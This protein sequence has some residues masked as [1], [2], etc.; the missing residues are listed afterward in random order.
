VNTDSLKADDILVAPLKNFESQKRFNWCFN[1]R[2]GTASIHWSLRDRV[3]ASAARSPISLSGL[4]KRKPIPKFM[5][6]VF[7]LIAGLLIAAT[8]QLML[9]NMGIAVG[10]T[11]L[12]W[13]PKSDRTNDS[14]P[15]AHDSELALPINHLLGLGLAISLSL[16]LFIASLLAVE[17]SQIAELRRGSILGVILWATYWLL[18]VWLSSTTLSGVVNSVLGTAIAAGRRLTNA[19]KQAFRRQQPDFTDINQAML[20]D[21]VTEV[22]QVAELQQY[23]PTLLAQQREQLVEDISDRTDLSPTEAESLIDDLGSRATA[24][25]S[26]SSSPSKSPLMAQLDLPSWQQLLRQVLD[27]VDLSDLDV[28]TL[29][30][31]LQSLADRD[32]ANAGEDAASDSVILVDAEDFVLNAP[33]WSFHPESLQETF[34]E[35]LYDPE[36]APEQIREQ[37]DKLDRD[38]WVRWLQKRGDLASDRIETVADRLHQVRDAVIET[39]ASSPAIVDFHPALEDAQEK[40]I[41]YCCYTNLDVL[42]P[43]SLM[44]KM[45]SV[46]QEANLPDSLPPKRVTQAN[47]A[48]LTDILSRRQGITDEKQQALVETLQAEWCA[49]ERS[50]SSDPALQQRLADA[51]KASLQSVDWSAVSLE[52]LKPELRNQLQSLDIRGE[53]DWSALGDHLQVPTEVKTELVDWLQET[54]QKLSRAPRR[55]AKRAGR[56]TQSFA[57]SLSHEVIHYLRFQEKTAF[58]PQQIAQDLAHILKSALGTLP[59]LSDLPDISELGHALNFE[60]LKAALENRRDMTIED[61]QQILDWLESAWHQSIRQ[62]SALPTT[63]WSEAQIIARSEIESLDAVRQRVVAQIVAAQQAMAA[64]AA[65]LK[66]DLQRQADVARRQVAI[67]AWWLFLSL[68]SSGSAAAI[69]GWLAVR[70]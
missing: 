45:Q 67:A 36:A 59:D 4:L 57:Q 69:A 61:I 16:V 30:H 20:R 29:W 53:L 42:T 7:S 6:I 60:A 35:R 31:Q 48:A 46:R 51:L 39:L 27:R 52:D 22:S 8:V 32:D 9:T 34:Y 5:N 12:D 18:F 37:L 62:M 28:E 38:H 10:L 44:E 13:S 49:D 65:A 40:L 1:C 33:V 23:L 25:A 58:Q 15:Q 41:A 70:Y 43:E 47:L 54:G 3:W 17:F 14:T 56:S 24:P 50:E 26:Q 64:R 63:L 2:K 11:V 68:L 66:A 55:W 19:L 21:L